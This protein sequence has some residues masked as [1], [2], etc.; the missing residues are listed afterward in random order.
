MQTC[1][2]ADADLDDDDDDDEVWCARLGRR[3]WCCVV[4]VGGMDTSEALC[5][6]SIIR[7]LGA[8]GNLLAEMAS[9]VLYICT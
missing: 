6:P 4:R 7:V 2:A 3:W 5:Y 8:Y 9:S 1:P